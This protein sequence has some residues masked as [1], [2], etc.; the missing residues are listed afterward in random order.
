MTDQRKNNSIVW[1][2]KCSC[3]RTH[4]AA[5][6]E[7][8]SHRLESCGCLKESK[9][10]RKI[11]K[12]LDENN[13]PY[14]TEKIFPNCKFEDSNQ[15]ARFDFYID[16]CFLLEFD[17][18]QHFKDCDEYYF[19]DNLQKR[20]QHDQYKNQWCKENHIPLKRIPYT[21]LDKITVD[22]IMGDEYLI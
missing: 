15:N 20:Q 11:K 19:K 6:N 10:V 17:G 18:I 12:L 1:E 7:L 16:N 9:G 5:A 13:I 2:C 4:Y 22:L 21:D 14:I 3:G 8:S